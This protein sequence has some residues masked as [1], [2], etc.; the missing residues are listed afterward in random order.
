MQIF[1]TQSRS[2]NLRFWNKYKLFILPFIIVFIILLINNLKVNSLFYIVLFL[3]LLSSVFYTLLYSKKDIYKIIINNKKL[4]FFGKKFN[5]DWKE[6]INLHKTVIEIKIVSNRNY[7][8][9]YYY[10]VIKSKYSKY[11]INFENNWKEI[12]ILNIFKTYKE[13][14]NEKIIIDEQLILN[15]LLEKIKKCQ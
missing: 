2:F 15:S 3:Y 10:I 5:N 13:L 9:K 14:K 12:E 1:E 4:I 7:C 6:T 8:K 11:I